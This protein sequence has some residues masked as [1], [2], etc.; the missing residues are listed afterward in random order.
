MRTA[1]VEA[2]EQ[3]GRCERHGGILKHNLSVVVSACGIKGKAA[4]KMAAAT[5]VS[6]KNELVRQGGI[7]PSQRVLGKFPRG[8]GHVLEEEELGQLGVLEHQTDSATEFGMSAKCRLESMKAF[9]R[10][11]C[12]SRL[13]RARLRQSGP[14]DMEFKAGDVNMYRKAEGPRWHGPRRIIG[15]DNKVLWT[16]HQGT[17]VAVATGRARPATVSEILVHMLL[18]DRVSERTI[19]Q[20]RAAGQQQGFVDISGRRRARSEVEADEQDEEPEQSPV[21]AR[22]NPAESSENPQPEQRLPGAGVE[23]RR[24]TSVE[25]EGEFQQPEAEPATP[26]EDSWQRRNPNVSPDPGVRH[27]GH[28]RGRPGSAAASSVADRERS[29]SRAQEEDIEATAENPRTLQR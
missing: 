14:I 13:A 3:I 2:A 25:D 19:D 28:L 23:V 4:M 10:Q 27:V 6:A 24:T 21:R 1:G 7:A 26:L 15:F 16:L 18:G 29:R 11:D 9:V 22:I 12:S 5:C 8:V 20:F 17:P